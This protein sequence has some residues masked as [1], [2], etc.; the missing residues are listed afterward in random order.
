MVYPTKIVEKD[1]KVD[2]PSIATS[3]VNAI[4]IQSCTV[5]QH[6]NTIMRSISAKSLKV[7]QI[8]TQIWILDCHTPH[9]SMSVTLCEARA[10]A[11]RKD[12]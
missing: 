6:L 10:E 1:N 5:M 12:A 9:L 11:G 3:D 7:S 4:H 8:P 2:M